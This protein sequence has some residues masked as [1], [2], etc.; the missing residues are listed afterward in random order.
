M[1]LHSNAE[2]NGRLKPALGIPPE[3]RERFKETPATEEEP[4]ALLLDERGVIQ[5]CSKTLE[6]LFGY[7]RIEIVWQHISCLFPQLSDYELIEAG[8]INPLLD[9]ICHCGHIF[10]GLDRKG[11]SIPNEL[12]LLHFNHNGLQTLKLIV[13][14]AYK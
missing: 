9:Y 8:R 13:R 3:G 10:L 11:R 12:S 2:R 4:P 5:D 14:P 6:N 1:K 7:R